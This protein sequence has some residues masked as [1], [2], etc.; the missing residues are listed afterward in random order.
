MSRYFMGGTK[1]EAFERM[2]MSTDRRGRDED[3]GSEDTEPQKAMQSGGKKE[4]IK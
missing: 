3:D 4:A 1:Y 2:M